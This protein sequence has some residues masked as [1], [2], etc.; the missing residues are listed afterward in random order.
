[1]MMHYSQQ[2]IFEMEYYQRTAFINSLSGFKSLNLVGT[3]NSK[4]ISNLAIFNSVMHIGAHPPLMGL[5]TRPDSVERHTL[6]NIRESSSY[7]IN[8]VCKDIFVQAHQTSARYDKEISEFDAVGLTPKF[9]SNFYAPFVQ[10][11]KV[12]IALRLQEIIL[13]RINQTYLVIGEIVEVYF[14]Q[15]ALLNDGVLDIELCNTICGSSL[16][17]YHETHLIERLKYAKP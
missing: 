14:P 15:D 5:V 8:H 12:Q 16:N 10:E 6:A 13:I 11:S 2:K 9:K 3:T 17:G 1:M 7:T 4:G